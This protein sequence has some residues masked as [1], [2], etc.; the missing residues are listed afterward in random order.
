MNQLSIRGFDKELE[1]RIR[2]V[3]KKRHLS[4]NKAAI[5]LLRRGAG[6]DEAHQSTGIVGDSLN[7]HIGSWTTADEAELLAN[8]EAFERIDEGLWS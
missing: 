2:E 4:L 6:L 3:A 5:L 1:R 7:E 8:T